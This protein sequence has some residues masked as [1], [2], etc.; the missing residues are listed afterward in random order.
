MNMNIKNQLEQDI[1]AAMLAGQKDTVT[2]LRGLKSAILYAEVASGQRSEGLTE[3]EILGVLAKE[4]KKRQ[5]SADLFEKGGNTEKAEA[6]K[7]EKALIESY[8]PEQLSRDEIADIVREVVSELGNDKQAMG[9]I[10]GAVKQ[11]TGNSADGAV[12]AQIV[13][14]AL[15]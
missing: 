5:E 6:E 3:D 7:V 14:D 12:I 10:I 13:K 2:T 11:R 9:R 8:L 1:K 4:A 15:Q